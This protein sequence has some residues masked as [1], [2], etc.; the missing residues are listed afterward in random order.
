MEFLRFFNNTGYF[1]IRM[2]QSFIDNVKVLDIKSKMTSKIFDF[3]KDDN[4]IGY[5]FLENVYY[6]TEGHHRMQ[7]ALELWKETGN[8][9][10]VRNLIKNGL[11]WDIKKKPNSYRF[12]I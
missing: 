1:S 3:K 7:A 10:Y 4:K 8:Y 2:T 5:E 9:E 6:I 11:K 12:K